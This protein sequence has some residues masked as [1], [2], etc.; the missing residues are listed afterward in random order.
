V[1]AA[2]QPHSEASPRG[3][4][5]EAED[6][7][8]GA[9][10][11]GGGT[12]VVV[13]GAGAGGGAG[14]TV[15]EVVVVVVGGTA[16]DVVV[17]VLMCAGFAARWKAA[18]TNADVFERCPAAWPKLTICTATT[19]LTASRTIGTN[20]RARLRRAWGEAMG[21]SSWVGNIG[22]ESLPMRAAWNP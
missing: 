13:V 4:T 22:A 5:P 1:T 9:G 15:V 6:S 17:V 12:V 7:A 11:A 3:G 2:A 19:A 21:Q 8:T 18:G 10:G 16:V 20:P 14:G